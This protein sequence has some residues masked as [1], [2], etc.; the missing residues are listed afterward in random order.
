MI[1]VDSPKLSHERKKNVN[2]KNEIKHVDFKLAFLDILIEHYKK[3]KSEG[4]EK[5]KRIIE[6]TLKYINDNDPV[7]NFIEENY[8]KSNSSKDKIKS[9]ELF[10]DF[11]NSNNGDNRNI[12]SIKFKTI[13][14]NMG[15]L[16]KR[17]KTGSY[18]LNI[19][20]KNKDEEVEELNPSIP[21]NPHIDTVLS[22]I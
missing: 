10:E 6:D 2:L 3:Y 15:F 8:E 13:L 21:S 11:K 16:H 12:N 4:I 9:S 19:K 7:S 5:P 17:E 18:Y 22:F 1:F 14:N 20:L